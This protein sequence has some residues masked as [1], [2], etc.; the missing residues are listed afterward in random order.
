MASWLSRP[1]RCLVSHA[2]HNRRQPERRVAGKGSAILEFSDQTTATWNPEWGPFAKKHC[3]KTGFYG[4]VGYPKVIRGWG[5]SIAISKDHYVHRYHENY[6][7]AAQSLYPKFMSMYED[8]TA[9][10]LWNWVYDAS[11]ATI[12]PVVRKAARRI[13]KRA[14]YGAI[15]A[16]GYD[17]H[18]VALDTTAFRVP[19][20]VRGTELYGTIRVIITDPL[21]IVTAKFEPKSRDALLQ[22]MSKEV[23][24]SVLPQ[25]RRRINQEAPPR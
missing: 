2:A 22:K 3:I 23:K 19:E 8:F 15:R 20:A 7:L 12:R 1:S 6:L 5:C 10:P 14:L 18:G 16:N 17:E 21:R 25:L 11:P 13:I 24:E 9:Y 4:R